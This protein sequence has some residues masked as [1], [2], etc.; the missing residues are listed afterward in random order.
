MPAAAITS[1]SPSFA[2]VTP[3]AP[4]AICICAISGV[5]C[6][7]ECGRHATPC[8]RHVATIRAMLASITSR[9]TSSA[10][11]SSAG[12]GLADQAA[13][14]IGSSVHR[15]TLLR[16]ATRALQTGGPVGVFDEAQRFEIVDGVGLERRAGLEAIDEMRDDAVEAR[17]IAGVG[18]VALAARRRAVQAQFGVRESGARL[19]ADDFQADPEDATDSRL[20]PS[21]PVTSTGTPD[22]VSR[23]MAATVSPTTSGTVRA[24]RAATTRNSPQRKRITSR[25]WIRTSAIISRSSYCV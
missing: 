25:W 23:K 18:I 1:A 9:S 24:P 19:A 22:A 4:A 5:L 13:R 12:L 7:F 8:A 16:L 6:A 14:Q 10:G 3:I 15:E 2:H 11:V 21:V 20:P 17:L